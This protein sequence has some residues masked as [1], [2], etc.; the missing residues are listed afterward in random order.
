MVE[1]ALGKPTANQDGFFSYK[2]KGYKSIEAMYEG[3]KCVLLEVHFSTDPGSWNKALT[4]L[5]LPTS[6]VKA[7]KGVESQ[8]GMSFPKSFVLEGVKGVPKKW[9]AVYT[10][11]QK[12]KDPDGKVQNLSASLLFSNMDHVLCTEEFVAKLAPPTS[13]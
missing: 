12:F 1:K 8:G 13:N 4:L 11:S 6:G 5:E 3:G 10:P 7:V 9:Q 2:R